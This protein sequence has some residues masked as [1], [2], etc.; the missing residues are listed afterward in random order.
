MIRTHRQTDKILE[1]IEK[2][3]NTYSKSSNFFINKYVYA[4]CIYAEL[5]FLLYA[6]FSLVFVD[7][8]N[9]LLHLCPGVFKNRNQK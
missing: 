3:M 1:V 4:I 2:S 6:R 9:E 5:K 7:S 8:F